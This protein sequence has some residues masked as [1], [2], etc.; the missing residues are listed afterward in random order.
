MT[1]VAHVL[2]RCASTTARPLQLVSPR[3]EVTLFQL[4]GLFV[5]LKDVV[6][7]STG[8]TT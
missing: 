5:A 7:L 6:S 4:I 1:D 2:I 8:G 3:F